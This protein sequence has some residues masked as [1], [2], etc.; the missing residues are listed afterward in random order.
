[1]AG[2]LYDPQTRLI[3][4]GARDY[5]P[6]VGRWISKDA[7][8]LAAGPMMYAYCEE[9][10][11]NTTD[12]AGAQLV[13]YPPL[14]AHCQLMPPPE[15]CQPVGGWYSCGYKAFERPGLKDHWVFLYW[16][17]VELAGLRD[18]AELPICFCWWRYHY[19]YK[20]VVRRYSFCREYTCPNKCC[21]RGKQRCEEEEVFRRPVPTI[22]WENKKVRT[23]GVWN[24][25]TRECL[26]ESPNS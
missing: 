19:S 18:S 1:F 10:P 16:E 9:D 12:P 7:V 2:A 26:C 3:R 14:P 6:Q 4:F 22:G 13:V 5:D 24:S 21:E 20:E 15:G 11:L 25:A 8:G 17:V 23:P